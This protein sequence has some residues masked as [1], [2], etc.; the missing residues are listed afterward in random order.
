MNSK[1]TPELSRRSFLKSSVVA[2]VSVA[3]SSVTA[4][5]EEREDV[6]EN[7]NSA[8]SANSRALLSRFNLK[9]P[10]FQAAPGGEDLAIA[11]CNN[12]AMGAISLTWSTPDDSFALVRKMNEATEGNYYANFVLH[13]DPV[14]LD[15]A[16]EAGCP[17]FQFSWGI[18][19]AEIVGRIRNAGAGLGIQ[20]SS[21]PNAVQALEREPDFLI[22]QGLEAGGHVQATSALR[23]SIQDVLD[24]AGDVPVLAAGGLS[25]GADMRNVMNDGAAGIVLGTRF[26][27][28]RE[29]DA[30]DVY[31][32]QLVDANDESTIYTI[33]FDKDWSAAMHRVLRNTTTRDWEAAG[34]PN[35]GNKP[36]ENDVVATHPVFGQATRYETVPPLVGHEG[37]LDEM[38]MY[39]GE[40]VGKVT[41]LP[42]AGDLIRRVWAEFENA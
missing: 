37:A 29:S 11:V 35:T 16:I 24:V 28:T 40:G 5:S 30:H 41:D 20:V 17:N 36:G 1:N 31:K 2:G 13:F 6:S 33:C 10:I 38:A 7:Q 34:C 18:P 27:A 32:Q 23:P 9:Y 42:S 12:G 14:S 22:C 15:K 19:D 26:M 21:G 8:L 4:V 39:A 3:A 25:T